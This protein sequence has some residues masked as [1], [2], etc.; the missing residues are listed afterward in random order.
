MVPCDLVPFVRE[1]E[2]PDV[3]DDLALG[4]GHVVVQ[5]SDKMPRH[6]I[7][8]LPLISFAELVPGRRSHGC[9]G[10]MVADVMAAIRGVYATTVEEVFIHYR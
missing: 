6:V 10:G 7:V 1:V 3:H 4:I 8:N 5:R 2:A 9:D